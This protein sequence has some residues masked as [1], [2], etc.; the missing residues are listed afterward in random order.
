MGLIDFVEAESD[1]DWQRAFDAGEARGR[2]WAAGEIERLRDRIAK[3]EKFAHMLGC[4]AQDGVVSWSLV[5]KKSLGEV[6]EA[7]IELFGGYDKE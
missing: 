2:E 3:L 6:S 4:W 5:D 7:Y 1:P